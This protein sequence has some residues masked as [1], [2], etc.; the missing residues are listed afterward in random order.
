M[1]AIRISS[2]RYGTLAGI[3]CAAARV[4]T[5]RMPDQAST[6]PPR[7]PRP[8]VAKKDASAWRRRMYLVIRSVR[9]VSGRS[10]FSMWRSAPSR[11][12]ACCCPLVRERRSQATRGTTNATRTT[13]STTVAI[14]P[15]AKA[16]QTLSPART[17]SCTSDF[18]WKPISRKTPLSSN[19]WMV[20]QFV[21]SVSRSW[22]ENRL[23][24]MVPVMSPATTT[25]STPEAWTSSAGMKA[26]KGTTKD[27][28]VVRTGSS[29][30]DRT[31]TDANPTA[32][33]TPMATRTA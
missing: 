8:W 22:A 7:H 30:F 15:R 1:N 16:S 19:S 12:S 29:T 3:D 32:A 2:E 5:P 13:T 10:L 6:A 28:D 9:G 11:N 17:T 33:P 21:R 26:A 18:S 25:E 23:A 31:Q 4:T 24:P 14:R 27:T 20:R